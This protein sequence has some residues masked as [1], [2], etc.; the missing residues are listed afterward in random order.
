MRQFSAA[1]RSFA[2]CASS[3]GPATMISASMPVIRP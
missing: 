3:S 2:I 1:S